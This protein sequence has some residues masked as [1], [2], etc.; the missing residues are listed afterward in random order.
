MGILMN[1]RSHR[2]IFFFFLCSSHTHT[3]TLI[4]FIYNNRKAFIFQTIKKKKR[5]QF[6]H[7]FCRASKIRFPRLCAFVTRFSQQC[8]IYAKRQRRRTPLNMQMRTHTPRKRETLHV[9]TQLHYWIRHAV[10]ILMVTKRY[11]L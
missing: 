10:M 2:V 11:A 8:T 5:T 3:R 1:E 6:L 4:T 7:V 9:I